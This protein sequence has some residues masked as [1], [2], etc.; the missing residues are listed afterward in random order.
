MLG[1]RIPID[2]S[3][4]QRVQR[5]T[6]LPLGK[7]YKKS[8]TDPAPTK[9]IASATT[10]RATGTLNRNKGMGNA[11]PNVRS[12]SATKKAIRSSDLRQKMAV[13][14]AADTTVKA[15]SIVTK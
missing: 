8:I 13:P 15:T 7:R 2:A 5:G 4:S 1:A 6:N 3:P 9:L 12:A 11:A 14:I 10:F